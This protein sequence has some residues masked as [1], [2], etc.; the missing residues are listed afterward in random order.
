M[1]VKDIDTLTDEVGTD[2]TDA[3][4]SK[5]DIKYTD[6]TDTTASWLN[7]EGTEGTASKLDIDTVASRLDTDTGARRLDSKYTDATDG[8]ETTDGTARWTKILDTG[9]VTC[10]AWLTG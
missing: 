1:D 9:G 5:L 4:A 10:W 6:A 8:T 7:T 3:I 2:A